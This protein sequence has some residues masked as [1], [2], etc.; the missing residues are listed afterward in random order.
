[1][2]CAALDWDKTIRDYVPCSPSSTIRMVRIVGL[3]TT[4]LPLC[5]NH[6]EWFEDQMAKFGGYL[7]TQKRVT[8]LPSKPTPG[9]FEG[10]KSP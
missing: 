2:S 4:E 9:R 8:V 6:R 10:L 5:D 1:M 3:V 7:D